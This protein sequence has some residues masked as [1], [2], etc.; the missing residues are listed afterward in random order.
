MNPKFRMQRP[1]SLIKN[2]K[3]GLQQ[4]LLNTNSCN[5]TVLFFVKPLFNH[6]SQTET[7]IVFF[8]RVSWPDKQHM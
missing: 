1:V 3:N 5:Y 2:T 4:K 7:E 8:P 6:N